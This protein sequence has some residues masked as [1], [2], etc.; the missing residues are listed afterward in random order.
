MSTS[1]T[2]RFAYAVPLRSS[3]A[4]GGGPRFHDLRHTGDTLASPIYQPG[5]REREREIA[6][7]IDVMIIK[8][9]GTRFPPERARGRHTALDR[10]REH[11]DPGSGIHPLTWA[12]VLQSGRRESNPRSQFGRLGLYH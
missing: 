6:D 1:T 3:P 12:Y 10:C 9:S 11:E 5:N 2:G 4:T 7:A 8:G